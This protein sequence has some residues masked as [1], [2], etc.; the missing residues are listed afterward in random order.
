MNKKMLVLVSAAIT[1]AVVAGIAVAVVADVGPR[2]EPTTEPSPARD[3][4]PVVAE[5][6]GQPIY[7]GEI[8]SRVAGISTVHGGLEESL[9]K[10]WQDDLLQNVVDDKIVEQQAAT[11]G[12]EVTQAQIDADIDELRGYFASEQE[13]D[14]WLE[15][16]RMDEAE[17][18]QRV[19]LQDLTTGVYLEVTDGVAPTVDEAKS[20]FRRHPDKY[21]GVDGQGVP[22][23]AVKDEILEDLEKAQRDEAYGAW[24]EEQ[25]GQVEVVVV[26]DGWWKEIA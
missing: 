14:A 13:F 2:T 11:L 25:R 20:W 21:P 10:N 9:G 3:P 18:R 4:G 5:V 1:V 8:R 16:G 23:F 7:L 22:F 19:L 15:Q 24:L 6:D 17:L 26:M 12:I